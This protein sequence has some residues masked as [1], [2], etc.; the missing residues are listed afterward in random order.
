M[1]FSARSKELRS[2]GFLFVYPSPLVN[3]INY[4]G[5]VEGS[6]ITDSI[7]LMFGA[8]CK[9]QTENHFTGQTSHCAQIADFLE[10]GYPRTSNHRERT[11]NLKATLN[12]SPNSSECSATY[13]LA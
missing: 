2:D 5:L 11:G 13:R 3:R 6:C 10:G 1:R 4:R 8:I 9:I 12:F 7:P